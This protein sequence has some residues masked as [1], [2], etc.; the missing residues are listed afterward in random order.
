M[1]GMLEPAQDPYGCLGRDLKSGVD[2]DEYDQIDK[3]LT[4]TLEVQREEK[5][6]LAERN[7]QIFTVIAIIASVAIANPALAMAF[8]AALTAAKMKMKRDISGEAYDSSGDTE[9]LLTNLL[10]DGGMVGV[11]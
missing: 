7:A 3:N 6:K 9:E 4:S 1:D 11:A 10:M 2:R 5:V 8:N